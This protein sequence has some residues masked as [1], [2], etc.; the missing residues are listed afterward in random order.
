MTD[1]VRFSFPL[2]P[3]MRSFMEL[4]DGLRCL[5]H[6]RQYNQPYAWLLAASDVRTSLLG[7]HGRK[8]AVPELIGLLSAMRTHLTQLAEGHPEFRVK[9]LEACDI[10]EDY[11]ESMRQGIHYAIDFFNQDALLSNYFNA[12]K[13]QDLLAHKPTLSQGL[14]VI[15]GGARHKDI[16]S[17]HLHDLHAAVA[18]LDVM[19]NDFVG[20]ESRIARLGS[21]QISPD[22]GAEY[23]L[24]VVGL[25]PAFVQQG[26]IPDCSGNRLAI[27]IRFQQWKA[28]EISSDIDDDL[29][30]YAMMVPVA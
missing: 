14:N 5:E 11:I 29:P 7:E 13:K 21:D 26:I 16:L 18:H 19:L 24:L 22:R 1:P 23:G 3:R 9:I 10:I 28:G 30:Y 8:Q 20:W 25:D 12:L 27:R 4:R 15:W 2:S 6:A 17:G